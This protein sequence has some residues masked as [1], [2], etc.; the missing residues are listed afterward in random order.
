DR[1]N[2]LANS[3]VFADF[4][5]NVKGRV[6]DNASVNG[7][8]VWGNYLN[9]V[10]NRNGN[11]ATK[12]NLQDLAIWNL[13]FD[14]AVNLG[15]LGAAQV[16]VGRFPL[17]LT[18]STLKFVDPDSYTSVPKLDF[19]DYV[20]DGGRATFNMG[21]T[22]L[23]LFAAKAGRVAEQWDTDTN[24]MSPNLMIDD[25]TN[26]E[27]V[28]QLA[29]ARAVIG[30]PLNG[31]LG[32]TYYEAGLAPDIGR[33]R[34]YGAD[35]NLMFANVGVAGEYAK[36]DPNKQMKN[37]AFPLL[38][39]GNDN[40][41]WN[42]KLS[43]NAGRLGI[44]AGYC[45]VGENYISPGYW[46]RTGRAV[47][48]TNIKGTTANVS[49]ALGNRLSIVAEGQFLKPDR[50]GATDTV[51]ARSAIEQ[52]RTYSVVAGNLD[53]VTYWKAGLKYGLTSVNAVDLGWEEAV[54]K[55]TTVAAQKTRERYISIGLGH[56]FNAN[57]GMKLLYQIVD[58]TAAGVANPYGDAT[59]RGGV[60]AAEFQMKY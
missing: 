53:T 50:N 3:D 38:D 33:A 7:T 49:Y 55:D 26:G 46:L 30:T 59:G 45:V 23:S 22:S 9:F 2:P 16:V 34:I 44:G 21:K 39:L 17:Q 6:S 10:L 58:F 54:W 47:N 36:F 14:G 40:I 12:D 31:N 57:A 19:G 4:D 15:P 42:A 5:F 37:I 32:L 52:G 56:T 51:F 24:L 60:A 1:N 13:N 11:L 29:G 27:Y 35:L 41:T 25:P 43:Y 20:V 28:P 18:P 8:L 48:L